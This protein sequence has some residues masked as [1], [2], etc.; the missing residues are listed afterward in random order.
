[1]FADGRV[2]IGLNTCFLF[3]IGW[4][5]ISDVMMFSEAAGF[6]LFDEIGIA[7]PALMLCCI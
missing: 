2:C 6:Y 4:W 3:G 7:H 1:M 5:M